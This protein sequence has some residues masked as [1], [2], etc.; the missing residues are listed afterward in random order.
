MLD[1]PQDTSH[2][3]ELQCYKWLKVL[4][5]SNLDDFLEEVHDM[6]LEGDTNSGVGSASM[7]AAINKVM[8]LFWTSSPASTSTQ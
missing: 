5:K 8:S 7:D 4:L 2:H 1:H 3:L 6:C